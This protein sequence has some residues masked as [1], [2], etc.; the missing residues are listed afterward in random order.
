MGEDQEDDQERDGV[1][2]LIRHV[3]I[4]FN[5]NYITITFILLLP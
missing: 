2:T 4:D 5:F 1:I 3:H